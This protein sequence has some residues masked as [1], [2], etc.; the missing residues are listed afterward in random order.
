VAR[1]GNPFGALRLNGRT[2]GTGTGV[3][4]VL[5]RMREGGASITS[6]MGMRTGAVV[7]IMLRKRIEDEKTIPS[8]NSRGSCK[9]RMSNDKLNI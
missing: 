6:V 3:V 7:M 1:K 2:G 9:K 5:D 4:V 8:N